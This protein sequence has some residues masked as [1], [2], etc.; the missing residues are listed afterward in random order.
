MQR[1]VR[2]FDQSLLTLRDFRKAAI[3]VPVGEKTP[4]AASSQW[5]SSGGA[6]AQDDDRAFRGVHHLTS[7]LLEDEVHPT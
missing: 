1:P 7:H 2:A 3:K 5:P 6:G 4:D